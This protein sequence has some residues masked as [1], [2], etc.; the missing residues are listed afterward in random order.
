V[1]TTL[2]FLNNRSA[3]G[4]LCFGPSLLSSIAL[5]LSIFGNSRCNLLTLN[6]SGLVSD[7]LPFAP[8]SFGLWCYE[9]VNG[10]LYDLRDYSFDSKYDA[11]RALG[12]TTLCLGWMI[13]I[14][15]LIAGCKR[16]PPHAFKF[17]GAIGILNT[18]F[19]GLVFLIYKSVVCSGGCSLDTGGKCAVS[20]V[21]MWFL[22]GITS[23]GAGKDAGESEGRHR[24]NHDNDNNEADEKPADKNDIEADA[25]PAEP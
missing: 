8:K 6:G 21:V 12:V 16:F 14:F 7:N 24:E 13:V 20:A 17:V 2:V 10:D 15:Y 3:S 25:K 22:T 4:V 23:C 5:I 1:H 19:Q 9:S 18:L 11:A